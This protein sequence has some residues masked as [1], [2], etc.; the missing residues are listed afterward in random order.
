VTPP[1]NSYMGWGRFNVYSH[2]ADVKVVERN[3]VTAV[4]GD[5]QQ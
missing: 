4:R 3:T 2:D 5:E 1:Q